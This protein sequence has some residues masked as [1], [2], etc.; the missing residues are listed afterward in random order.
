MAIG[1]KKNSKADQFLDLTVESM[2]APQRQL[3]S[4]D[5][6]FD[7]NGKPL[8]GRYRDGTTPAK[9]K[10]AYGT[11]QIQIGTARNTA[12]KHGIPWDQQKL[13]YD[14]EYN[15]TLGDLHMDDLKKT[16]N[17]DM[18]LVYAAYHSG[19]PR[20]NRALARH[21][22]N[23]FT[24]GLGPEGR[25]YVKRL[26]GEGSGGGGADAVLS[27]VGDLVSLTPADPKKFEEYR[28]Q[29]KTFQVADPFVAGV[30]AGLRTDQVSRAL[31]TEGQVLQADA[32]EQ[33]RIQDERLS[34]LQ[35]ANEIKAELI[36]HSVE[37]NNVFRQRNA[38]LREQR[39]SVQA[40]ER[41][42]A[43]MNPLERFFKRVGNPEYRRSTIANQKATVAEE[44]T[45]AEV[46]WKED[47]AAFRVDVD[48]LRAS[49][50]GADQISVLESANS[51]QDAV[52]AERNSVF[53]GKS[54]NQVMQSVQN[55]TAI[56]SAQ[57]NAHNDL[58]NNMTDDML[59]SSLNAAT[60]GGGKAVI[61]G[62][63]LTQQQ[64]ERASQARIEVNIGLESRQLAL[65]GNRMELADNIETRTIQSMTPEMRSKALQDGGVYNGEQLNM[66]KLTQAVA[67]DKQVMGEA[68]RR[69]EATE[70]PARLGADIRNLGGRVQASGRML[71]QMYGYEPQ[72]FKQYT[73]KYIGEMN[74]I[75]SIM[76]QANKQGL[77]AE[78]ALRLQP[79]VD[80]LN[81][82][83]RQVIQSAAK[84]FGGSNKSLQAVGKAWFTGAP[85]APQEAANAVAAWAQT[86]LP[87]GI[88]AT[89][90]TKQILNQAFAAVAANAKKNGGKVDP[91]V[92]QPMIMRFIGEK[93]ADMRLNRV[94]KAMPQLAAKHKSPLRQINPTDFNYAVE[95][96]DEMGLESVADE[97]GM[98]TEEAE[99]KAK[100][101]SKLATAIMAAQTQSTLKH[102]DSTFG[103]PDFVPSQ[104]MAKLFSDER[105]LAD[106][107]SVAVRHNEYSMPDFIVTQ[108]AGADFHRQ[109]GA[110]QK[111]VIQAGGAARKQI[112]K[113]STLDSVQL[114]NNPFL[115]TQFILNS[116]PGVSKG[117]KQF[118]LDH[119]Q[120]VIPGMKKEYKQPAAGNLPT[121]IITGISS[122]G[123]GHG[124]QR[125]RGLDA[126]A[127]NGAGEVMDTITS[128]IVGQK[129][130]DPKLESIRKR[131]AGDWASASELLTRGFAN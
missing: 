57:E 89:G 105:F 29:S 11:S 62:I 20:V 59:A 99:T 16:Y 69:A 101:D 58:I 32:A 104:E 119:L 48:N 113:D 95:L 106:A 24:K 126:T 61:Q 34:R 82:E 7:K 31:Q 71:T 63:E 18:A 15:A 17:N 21:G 127:I 47:Q 53:A 102:L 9:G 51:N 108:I 26:A 22:R 120:T 25:N 1:F 37:S 38:Q 112:M 93:V 80:K 107:H 78:T 52:L 23:Q 12:K 73:T 85:L 111:S 8:V 76:N 77:G 14:K 75:A 56:D 98:T 90:E 30:Q 10:E 84:D 125:A 42:L 124:L 28:G 83:Y 109:L 64:L 103:G 70:A 116:V 81:E 128:Y 36:R 100:T 60:V 74:Q 27:A 114:R 4:G 92:V 13:L 2:S 96:G 79:R 33:Q 45:D 65:Q 3:E 115:R 94:L 97:L 46:D 19:E 123:G 130:A 121:A 41:E 68:L 87:A 44:F 40:K 118:L 43:G 91:K 88:V 50:E 72:G 110:Y 39:D 6:Q 35:D 49:L 66:N 131:V 67:N 117:E 55:Q 129:F 5:K 122:L 54:L 86:G